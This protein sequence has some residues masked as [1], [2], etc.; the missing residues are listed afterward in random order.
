MMSF[1][2]LCGNFVL[3]FLSVSSCY[4]EPL[5][6]SSSLDGSPRSGWRPREGVLLTTLREHYGAVNRLMVA[7]DQSYFASVSADRT[8]KIWQTKNIDKAAFPRWCLFLKE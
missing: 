8:A 1:L 3:F 2:F 4:I 6:L 7:P 5:D